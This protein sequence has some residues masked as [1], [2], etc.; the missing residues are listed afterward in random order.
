MLQQQCKWMSVC[1]EPLGHSEGA[2]SSPLSLD[3]FDFQLRASIRA[4]IE[5][6]NA[7]LALDDTLLLLLPI[8]LKLLELFSSSTKLL[9][10]EDCTLMT[11]YFVKQIIL[12]RFW[13]VLVCD[14]FKKA[15]FSANFFLLNCF[16]HHSWSLETVF[17]LLC[18][19][20]KI[21]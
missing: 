20:F 4:Y 19:R 14:Y 9:L 5:A 16:Y 15:D 2:F 7:A 18:L 6:R 8:S 3:N 12:Q 10:E 11:D 13:A 1:L 21:S 17:L